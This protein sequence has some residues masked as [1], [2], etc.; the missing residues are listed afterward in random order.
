MKIIKRKFLL[1][2]ILILLLALIPRSVEVLSGNYL[3]GF[4][5]G[6][7]Y[8]DVKKIVVDHKLT[9]IGTQVGGLGRFFQGPGWYYLLLISFFFFCVDSYFWM[10]FLFII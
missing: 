8:D 5:Q 2:S 1:I 6:Q 3:F 10:V 9:L 7:F 4:D